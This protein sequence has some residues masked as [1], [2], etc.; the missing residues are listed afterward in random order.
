MT[1]EWLT[2]K[3][4]DID[5]TISI[6]TSPGKHR[7]TI[8]LQ[9]RHQY[10]LDYCKYLNKEYQKFLIIHY[11]LVLVMKSLN[12]HSYHYLISKQMKLLIISLKMVN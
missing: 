4:I 2:H 9:T 1:F 11:R 7:F 3:L 10:Y 12:S 6:Y 5:P 8:L